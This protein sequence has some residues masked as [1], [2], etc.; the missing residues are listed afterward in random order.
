MPQIP[1]KNHK[2]SLSFSLTKLHNNYIEFATL[3]ISPFH[4]SYPLC[5]LTS[6]IRMTAV[7]TTSQAPPKY[8][9]SYRPVYV[10]LTN[11]KGGNCIYS[12]SSTF[13]LVISKKNLGLGLLVLLEVGLVPMYYLGCA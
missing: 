11:Q 1:Q 4:F 9:F 13:T 3:S 12:F 7:E 6:Q 2:L 5:K 10:N 8:V